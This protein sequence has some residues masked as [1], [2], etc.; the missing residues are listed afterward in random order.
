MIG[1][2]RV[3]IV[4]DEPLARQRLVR[5]VGGVA[6]AEVVGVHESAESLLLRLD[7]EAPDVLLL[8]IRLGGLSGTDLHAML[9]ERAPAIVYVT[10]HAEHA[11]CAFDLAATD[12]VLKPVDAGRLARALAR[13]RRSPD[14]AEAGPRGAGVRVPISTRDGV[15]LLDPRDIAC[16]VLDGVLIEIR[17]VA[18]DRYFADNALAHLEERLA[19]HGF[20]RVHRR[21]LV[22]LAAVDRLVPTPG[23]GYVAQLRGGGSVT[24][25]RQSARRLRRAL[26]LR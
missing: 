16:A 21:A 6:S 14:R 19:A 17:T 5:L 2:L 26:G 23:G 9:G 22:N 3:A 25:S 15:V 4:D 1:R 13:A 7:R 18:G 12:Y 10:A 20:S 11:A 24:V 8:D